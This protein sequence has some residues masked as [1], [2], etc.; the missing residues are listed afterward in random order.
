M[1]TQ[2][3]QRIQKLLRSEISTIIQ[4]KLKD[5]RVG[6]VT[7]MRLEVAPDLS[8]ARV[9]VSLHGGPSAETLALE[10]LTS[11]AG[12]IRA[13]LMS[14]LHLRP[15]PH[16]DFQVDAALD[17]EARTLD[18]LE[19]IRREQEQHDSGAEPGDRSDPE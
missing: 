11:A 2:R 13:E 8:L 19:Q 3:L 10:G 15:M 4:R 14:V 6:M 12:F 17:W 1:A 5:P 16:L 9:F 7:I 18:I